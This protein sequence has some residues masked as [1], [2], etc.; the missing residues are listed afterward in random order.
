VRKLRA[1]ENEIES[2]KVQSLEIAGQRW[3]GEASPPTAV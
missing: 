3:P 2:L 1:G